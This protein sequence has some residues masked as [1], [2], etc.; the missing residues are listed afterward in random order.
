MIVM[1]YSFT[2][3]FFYYMNKTIRFLNEKT[4]LRKLFLCE[5]EFPINLFTN[6][7]RNERRF[8][9]IIFFSELTMTNDI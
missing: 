5:Y 9:I 8:L 3:N 6:N 4:E 7:N 2:R 1:L